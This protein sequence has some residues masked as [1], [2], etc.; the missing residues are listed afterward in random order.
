[1]VSAGRP[2]QNR[3]RCGSSS[4][5]P[6]G[7]RAHSEPQRPTKHAPPCSAVPP[8]KGPFFGFPHRSPAAPAAR[9]LAPAAA[10]RKS[11]RATATASGATSSFS[12]DS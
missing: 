3:R 5:R 1:M 4:R 7:T 8:L 6:R 11:S 9:P 2:A 12:S 10:A